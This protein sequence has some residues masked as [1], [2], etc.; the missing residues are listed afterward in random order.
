MVNIIDESALNGGAA[1]GQLGHHS[2]GASK[3][4]L[5]RS[6]SRVAYSLLVSPEH[7]GT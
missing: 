1:E 5:M 6:A 7:G 2:N 4:N 3:L